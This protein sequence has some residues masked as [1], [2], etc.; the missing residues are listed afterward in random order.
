MNA[1]V[2]HNSAFMLRDFAYEQTPNCPEIPT[3]EPCS[4]PSDG[5]VDVRFDHNTSILVGAAYR[6]AWSTNT[7]VFEDTMVSVSRP[8]VARG[9]LLAG[10]N[11]NLH[12]IGNTIEAQNVGIASGSG[13]PPNPKAVIQGNTITAGPGRPGISAGIG[14]G[15]GA[16]VESSI[17]D[18][19]IRGLQGAGIALLAGNTGNFVRGNIVEDNGGDGI[20][21]AVGTTNNT[22]E[23][24]RMHGNRGVDARD[25]A[26]TDG[27]PVNTW[28]ANDCVTDF[29]VGTIC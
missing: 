1:H 22:F 25:A 4:S 8:T 3:T 15:A 6:L 27:L 11:K 10:A 29:P 17:L 21:A 26:G 2:H 20:S 13:S 23:S 7:S 5:M 18:N 19:V 9:V 28:R 16:L 12:I 14:M 24:N